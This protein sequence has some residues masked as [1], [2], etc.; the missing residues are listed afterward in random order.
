MGANVG[1]IDKEVIEVF[2]RDEVSSGSAHL[3]R[4]VGTKIETVTLMDGDDY[5]R[6]IDKVGSIVT[7]I[8]MSRVSRIR[9]V[10]PELVTSNRRWLSATE[11]EREFG[12][13]R[14]RR[15]AL[16][17]T[18]DRD[19]LLGTLEEIREAVGLPPGIDPDMVVATVKG[20]RGVGGVLHLA[21]EVAKLEREIENLTVELP[22]G[23]E[24]AA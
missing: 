21:R 8:E 13:H 9:R 19:A 3:A 4:V 2:F 7:S 5:L 17:V 11:G 20:L 22:D 10:D 12:L 1:Q 16:E 6:V 15:D 23:M 18:E 14:E 24:E